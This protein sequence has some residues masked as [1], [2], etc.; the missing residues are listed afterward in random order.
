M[1]NRLQAATHRDDVDVQDT[2]LRGHK[3][4]VDEVGC[5][6]QGARDAFATP[7]ETHPWTR[8]SGTSVCP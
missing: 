2:L 1:E 8:Y 3:L 4:E 6:T 5:E 7:T